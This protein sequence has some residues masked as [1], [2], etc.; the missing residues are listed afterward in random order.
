MKT[1]RRAA[2][3]RSAFAYPRTKS[4][5]IDTKARA[6]NALARAS[7]SHT[8]GTYEHV[9]RAVRRYWGNAIGTVSRSRGTVTGPGYRKHGGHRRR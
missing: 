9:A 1:R 2:L 4:Y 5:P 8:K 3:P 6:R 7:Q